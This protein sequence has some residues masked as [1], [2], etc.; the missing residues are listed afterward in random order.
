MGSRVN[1]DVGAFDWGPLATKCPVCR[2][3]DGLLVCGG[4]KV[5]HY[6]GAA[7]QADHRPTHKS[8]CVA[9]KKTRAKLEEEEAT[10]RANPGD[11][12]SM[13]ADVFNNGVGAF[14]GILDTRDY[15]RARFA[16]ADALLQVQT[17]SA[18]E[19]ALAHFTDM[20]R[21]C[22]SDNL[23]VRDIVPGLLL[24]LGREQ[25]CYDFIKW[26]ATIND[27]DRYNGDYDWGN[28][29]LPHLDLHGEDPFEAIDRVAAGSLS[30]VVILTLLKLRLILDL[31]R[32]ENGLGE[33]DRPLGSLVQKRVRSRSRSAISTKELR[34]QYQKLL[35]IVH[36][37]NSHFWEMLV[38]GETPVMQ[39][40][41]TNGSVEEAHLALYQCLP[42]WEESEDAIVML[43]ADT[44]QLVTRPAPSPDIG[45]G[46]GD[47]L[48]AGLENLKITKPQSATEYAFPFIFQAPTPTIGPADLFP[49]TRIGPNQIVR[50]VCQIDPSMALAYADG[51][52]SN[53]GQPEPRGGWAVILAPPANGGVLSGRLEDSQD[54]A[55]TSNRAEL[56]AAVAA[57]RLRN[58]EGLGLKCIVIATD[59]TYIVNGATK[60]AKT[61][62][63]NGWKTRAGADAKN[64]DLWELLLSEVGKCK[65]NGLRVDLWSI[66]R[67]LNSDADAAAK[68]AA[69]TEVT[70]I[71][72]ALP[73]D[74]IS[75]T[76]PYI[77]ALCFDY[78]ELFDNVFKSLVSKLA[79]KA[80]MVR[81]TTPNAALAQLKQ[82]PL[83]SIILVADGAITR[84]KK[85][86][87][88][89]IDLLRDGATVV[90][91]GCFSNMV[92]EGQ[93]TRFFTEI[94]LP[95]SRGGYGREDV[96][97]HRHVL[98]S[99]LAS[100]L[101]SSYS[102]R[103]LFAKNVAPSAA[104]YTVDG[105]RSEAAV[106]FAKVGAGHLGYIG[107]VNGE[108][109][110]DT[111]VLAMCGL[112]G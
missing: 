71:T 68:Q 47:S 98:D 111:V 57:L 24:R 66:G 79:A 54:K 56:R 58:W 16:A 23:G 97:L 78:E 18:V 110:S 104:W 32:F 76:D 10:L 89:V 70:S 95:W 77:L 14:W 75:D 34:K 80:K 6:C 103:A 46:D 63:T 100:R 96:S 49:P 88:R 13:P 42:A 82:Q 109:S 45:D 9:I 84:E 41:Y 7:H 102:Q 87:E 72:E 21:L 35:R 92:S 60:W 52:C 108:E 55:A 61:W 26:W 2:V 91:A 27:E 69:S 64:K 38:G 40:V 85:V 62:V 11:N 83:P 28:Y 105:N 74:V 86:R 93:F 65:A 25:E 30:H 4:C 31:E 106:A 59:S 44:V 22:R 51:A 101:P 15:M 43:D 67:E 50:F 48:W 3:K 33:W 81:A 12:F 36:D 17:V 99:R 19:K 5:V 1:S 8:A 39:Q 20:L 112:L 107:D 53:N 37:H 90:L 94:G 73:S 29:E